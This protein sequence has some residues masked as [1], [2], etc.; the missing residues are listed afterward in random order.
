MKKPQ[1]THIIYACTLVFSLLFLLV[2]NRVAQGGGRIFGAAVEEEIFRAQVLRVIS[3]DKD[4]YD[5]AGAGGFTV[6]TITFEARALS[7]S[8]KGKTLRCVQEIDNM[9]ALQSPKVQEGDTILLDVLDEEG[10]QGTAHA[11]DRYLFFD[12][13][14]TSPLLMLALVFALLVVFFGRKKGFD[15]VLSLVLTVLAI[16]TVLV[17]AV[18]TGRNIYLWSLLICVFIVMTNLLLV[19]G[20]SAKSLTAALGCVGGVLASGLI[21][22]LMNRPMHITGLLDEESI[23]LLQ[24]NPNNP[25]N[26]KATVF[27]MILIGSVGALMDVSMSIAS[28]L[29][30]IR[31]KEPS[32]PAKELMRSGFNIGKDMIGTMANTLVLAYIGG[33]MSIILL[34]ISYSANLT[35]ML[36]KELIAVEILQ[37]LAGSMSVVIAIPLTSLICSVFYRGG[38][39]TLR[40]ESE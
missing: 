36:N 22:L 26:I 3:E 16:F 14:R 17:P 31:E 37:S 11:G 38:K 34:M 12:F 25:I 21:M 10:A 5:T 24:L 8:R 27:C 4:T 19:Q 40:V 35:Q 18:L 9:F 39:K 15:T 7:G 2:G 33:S 30:E 28:A 20:G 6:T 13:V 29:Q 32:L 1:R 23:F